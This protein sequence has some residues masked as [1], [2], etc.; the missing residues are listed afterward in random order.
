MIK[1]GLGLSIAV[2]LSMVSA[3][4]HA[5][6]GK[7][8]V[9]WMD[10]NFSIIE[11][12]EAAQ[13]YKEL[14]VIKD[15]AEIPVTWDRWSG[16]PGDKWRVLL[17][18]EVAFE[19]SIKASASQKGTGTVRVTQGGQ[20]DMVVELCAG[21]GAEESC[22]RSEAKK[23]VV[24]DTD[25]SHL[26]PLKMNIDP[27][28]GNYTTPEGKVAGA[29]FV[30]W[31]VY[32]RKYAV[33]Q[34]PA[35][36]LTHL[37]YGFIPIC[38]PNPSLGAIEEGNSLAALNRACK[39]TADYEV[40]I[41]DP[42]AAVQMPHKQSGHEFSTPYKGT[43]GQLMALKKGYPDLKIIPSIGG[44]TLSDPFF[45][46]DDK[47]NRDTFVA[48]VKKFLKTWKFYDGVDIDWEFPGGDGAN[49]E[50]GDPD[51]DGKV[52]VALMA[53]LRA[54]LDELSAE[55]GREYEL[56]SAIGVGYDKIQDVNYADAI[57]YMDYIFAMSYDFYG[58][59]NNDVGHQTAIYCG[60]Q[61][62][63]GECD[64]TGLDAKGQ[65][66]KGPAYTAD[67]GIQML[68]KQ[69]VP[70]NKLVLGAAMYGRGWTGVTEAS[71]TDP[72]NPMTGKGNGPVSG[73]WEGGIFDYK[74]MVDKYF[75][76]AGVI[77][78]YDE[79]AEAAYVYDPSNGDLVSYD[80][81]RSIMAKGE[82]VD[83]L[84]LAG[85]FAWEID[86]DNGDILNAMQEALA[87]GGN[88]A[89]NRLPTA[90]AGDMI[91]LTE[92]G[93]V[94][95][96]G[97]ASKDRDGEIVSYTWTQISG[98][99]L[100]LTT[101]D[102]VKASVFVPVTEIAKTYVFE[103]TVVDNDG[104]TATDTVSIKAQVQAEVENTAPTVV[105][106]GVTTAKTGDIVILDAVKSSD[107]EGD[108][109]TYSW[110]SPD[111]V[112]VVVDGTTLRF[113][114]AKYDVDTL[115]NFGLSVSDGV[116][117]TQSV[118]RVTVAATQ[119]D[120][121]GETCDT[122]A[123]WDKG[124]TYN[125]GETVSHNGEYW[126]AGWWTQ[127]EPGTTGDWGEWQKVTNPCSGTD[128]GSDNSNTDGGNTDGGDSNGSGEVCGVNW[129]MSSSYSGGDVVQHN[130]ESW[131]AKWWTNSEPGKSSEWVKT[132][133]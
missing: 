37:L 87:I 68:L 38:G 10:T 33:D 29:Y 125:G 47:A 43:Y 98:E 85:L 6:P 46:F 93:D 1:H 54:M 114:A 95:L 81:P 91:N 18:G 16:T 42:W 21:E 99:T 133:C 128:G 30:E 20:Y 76:K 8:Q 19:Q 62:S 55:T 45:Y 97:S 78:G 74:D 115:L 120:G 131:K 49:T 80:S 110:S 28:N 92:S 44:W 105:I 89:G 69:G 17:N 123:A 52:Y 111:G 64:G 66:R 109:L 86:A 90:D 7:P 5:S 132:D 56:T 9:G 36:N 22:S 15:A 83:R 116:N 35:Q 108:T 50:L 71:M 104:A 14:V 26:D 103:L 67:N 2:A 107:A 100:I 94:M 72:M 48:S 113:V 75:N 34:I 119:T 121:G 117:T 124:V 130:G 51:N 65:P 24:A 59:W 57:P 112:E 102:K 88:D 39:G 3:N 25:G 4:A 129:E 122:A 101:S 41:H 12:S 118:W 61:M 13:A 63:T 53:E 84:G 79:Q 96:D 127:K 126:K 58:A 31:G 32:G 40:V 11:V 106:E 73:T 82:Y 77:K 70:A 60:T 27:N 23:I